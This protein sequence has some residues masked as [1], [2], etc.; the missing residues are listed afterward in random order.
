M[1][2]NNKDEPNF[3]KSR[4]SN[5]PSQSNLKLQYYYLS[6]HDSKVPLSSKQISAN[7]IYFQALKGKRNIKTEHQVSIIHPYNYIPPYALFPSNIIILS[8]IC[9]IHKQTHTHYFWLVTWS[10]Y[11]VPN[12]M[13]NMFNNITTIT[14]WHEKERK[15][16]KEGEISSL[17]I[18]WSWW[19]VKLL[20]QIEVNNTQ[21]L[22]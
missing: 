18:W 6:D 9:L 3:H 12:L 20:G 7:K 16:E 1:E 19:T 17:H 14:W 4:L 22:I 10:N 2:K 21:V 15:R 13:P 8:K 11:A 5:K